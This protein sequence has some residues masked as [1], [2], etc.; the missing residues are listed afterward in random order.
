MCYGVFMLMSRSSVEL[1][2]A[3]STV[4]ERSESL[5]LSLLI[6]SY[7][8]LLTDDS[9]SPNACHSA[10]EAMKNKLSV[11]HGAMQSRQHPVDFHR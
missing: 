7:V 5:S 8:C 10:I 11:V 2:K 9:T 6:T 1:P 3:R 4:Q